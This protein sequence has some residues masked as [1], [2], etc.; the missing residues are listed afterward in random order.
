MPVTF[1]DGH[2]LPTRTR[3]NDP[4][5]QF[6]PLKYCIFTSAD[7][8]FRRKHLHVTHTR[9]SLV[10]CGVNRAPG[11]GQSEFLLSE[12]TIAAQWLAQLTFFMID[13]FITTH[14]LKLSV[15]LWF[16][17]PD[18]YCMSHAPTLLLWPCS[19]KT[20]KNY[21]KAVI[22]TREILVVPTNHAHPLYLLLPSIT[23]YVILLSSKKSARFS[24]NSFYN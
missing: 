24:V 21:P 11:N 12:V 23:T 5:F 1:N 13:F 9:G 22:K 8:L 15:L 7:I 16:R 4:D 20:K 10:A 17:F 19:S 2:L 6:L 3:N 14:S 18:M